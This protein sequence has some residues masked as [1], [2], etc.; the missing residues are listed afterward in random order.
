MQM[1]LSEVDVINEALDREGVAAITAVVQAPVAVSATSGEGAAGDVGEPGARSLKATRDFTRFSRCSEERTWPSV[2]HLLRDGAA[3]TGGLGPLMT[4]EHQV[5]FCF[6][7]HGCLADVG[8]SP[9]D[10]MCYLYSEFSLTWRAW[11]F[12]SELWLF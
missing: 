8:A 2:R 10:Y 5:Y 1:A 12:N 9:L 4:W 11:G 7:G 3:K 6:K